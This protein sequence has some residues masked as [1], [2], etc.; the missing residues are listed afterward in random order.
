MVDY[1][2]KIADKSLQIYQT[3]PVA[4]TLGALIAG[5][6]V[7]GHF[8]EAFT[9]NMSRKAV[10]ITGCDFGMGKATALA[11]AKKG[12]YVYAGCLRPE[13]SLTIT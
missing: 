5:Y 6:N 13:V 8:L 2:N 4:T 3:H 1:L 7:F 12:F 9:L 10:F 11:M